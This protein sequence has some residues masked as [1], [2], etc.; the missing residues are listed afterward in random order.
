MK[1][2]KFI[3]ALI[4]LIVIYFTASAQTENTIDSL[5]KIEQECSNSGWRMQ[6]CSFRFM[7]EMDSI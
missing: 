4:F 6:N 5:Q 1:T 7:N 3:F 2:L